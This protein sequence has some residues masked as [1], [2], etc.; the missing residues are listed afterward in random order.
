MKAP[1]G[2]LVSFSN[3][4]VDFDLQ[5]LFLQKQFFNLGFC[6]TKRLFEI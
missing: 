1:L 4:L 5:L 3:L 6:G 2:K